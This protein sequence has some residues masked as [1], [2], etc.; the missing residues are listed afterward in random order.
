[1]YSSFTNKQR[2]MSL[3][4]SHIL[5][6]KV[7]FQLFMDYRSQHTRIGYDKGSSQCPWI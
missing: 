2:F 7:S 4:A 3:Q 1:M 6:N 5:P